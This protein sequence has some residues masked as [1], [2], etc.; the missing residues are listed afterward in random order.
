[1]TNEVPQWAI[2]LWPP[3][4][5][6][7]A[8]GIKTSETR[9]WSPPLGQRH[10]PLAIHQG[11]RQPTRAEVDHLTDAL[12]AICRFDPDPDRRWRAQCAVDMVAEGNYPLGQFVAEVHLGGTCVVESRGGGTEAW[13]HCRDTTTGDTFR[14]TDD[15]LGDYSIGRHI[16]RFPEIRALNWPFAA[17]G[18]QGL[19]RIPDNLKPFLGP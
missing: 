2:T 12:M 18:R 5:S 7:I 9:H 16:W 3:W 14:V 17:R 6:L 11:K 8:Y 19:W 1:M 10:M 13:A 15:G 4:G